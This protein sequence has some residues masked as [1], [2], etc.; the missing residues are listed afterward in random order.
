MISFLFKF[1]DDNVDD[2]IK[3]SLTMT[4]YYGK[5]LIFEYHKKSYLWYKS[6]L[7]KQNKEQNIIKNVIYINR[8]IK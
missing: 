7:N 2:T 1:Y 6:E 3:D 4:Y 8:I 5:Y